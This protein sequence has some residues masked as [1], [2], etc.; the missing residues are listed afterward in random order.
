MVLHPGDGAPGARPACAPPLRVRRTCGVLAGGCGALLRRREPDPVRVGRL[1]RRDGRR[2]PARQPPRRPAR[3]CRAPRRG[4]ERGDH[5]LQPPRSLGG[6]LRLH[7]APV[8]D[9]L[10]RRLCAPH[11]GRAGG[12]GGTAGGPGRA[13]A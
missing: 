8:R 11:A 5:R 1:P 6:R 4:G 10:A 12:G 2:L 13:R 7:P 3:A 9:R